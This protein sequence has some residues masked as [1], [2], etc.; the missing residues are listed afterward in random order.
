VQI[1]PAE[2]EVCAGLADLGAILH[3]ANVMRLGMVSALVQ[4]VLNRFEADVVAGRALFDAATHFL[5]DVLMLHVNSWTKN[6]AIRSGWE[7][8]I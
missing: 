4:A 7:G 1:R 2:H 6:G 3:Q 8:E 5:A